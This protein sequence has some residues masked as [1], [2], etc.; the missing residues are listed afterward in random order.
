[1]EERA[2]Q[3]EKLKI[4]VCDDTA[5]HGAKR[6]VV[7]AQTHETAKEA[8]EENQHCRMGRSRKGECG[9]REK[10][11]KKKEVSG[12]HQVGDKGAGTRGWA[13][14]WIGKRGKV[15]ELHVKFT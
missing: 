14:K 1:M 12:G 15:G 6:N 11:G 4:A 7:A 2:G 3:F 10:S 13:Y 8:V 5:D 9:W